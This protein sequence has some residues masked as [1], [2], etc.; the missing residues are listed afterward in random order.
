MNRPNARTQTSSKQPPEATAGLVRSLN[1]QAVL[2][3]IAG[4]DELSRPEVSSLTGLSL[5]TVASLIADLE[6]LGLVGRKGQSIGAP[7]RP[8]AI[9]SF[10]ERAGTIRSCFGRI[11]FNS[12]LSSDN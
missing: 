5:P 6:A 8:A 1:L 10:N 9:Y 11:Y 7:G 12:Q 3:A 2:E 4:A